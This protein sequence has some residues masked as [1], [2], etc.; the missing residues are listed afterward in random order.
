M[1]CITGRSFVPQPVFC[2]RARGLE[3]DLLPAFAVYSI[4]GAEISMKFETAQLLLYVS[5]LGF[6]LLQEIVGW[7]RWDLSLI[8]G[9]L[10]LRTT[11][12]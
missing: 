1:P 10:T 5:K 11:P 8:L 6:R 9:G 4:S 3:C 2:S 12:S 7:R